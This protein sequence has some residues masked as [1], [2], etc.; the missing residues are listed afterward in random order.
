MDAQFLIVPFDTLSHLTILC[1]AYLGRQ[2]SSHIV[3][4]TSIS[5]FWRILVVVA[6]PEF[7]AVASG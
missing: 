3:T 4:S 5:S 7:C 1:M 6:T 2:E